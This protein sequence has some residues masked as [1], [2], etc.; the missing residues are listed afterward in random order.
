MSDQDN[1][2]D[3]RC[4]ALLVNG[5]DELMAFWRP[6]SLVAAMHWLD[7]CESPIEKLMCASLSFGLHASN[8]GMM[9]HSAFYKPQGDV[10]IQ[11]QAQLGDYRVD[12]ALVANERW[13]SDLNVEAKIVIEC[14]GHDFHER[15]KEQ[16]ERDRSRDRVLTTMGW[17]VLRFTGREIVRDPMACVISVGD[18]IRA[19]FQRQGARYHETMTAADAAE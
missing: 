17:T 19:E 16:A 15:T 18:A 2:L 3:Q 14:D 1:E 12:F 13:A 7:E 5:F 10:H 6:N 8:T 4:V 11:P 9:L